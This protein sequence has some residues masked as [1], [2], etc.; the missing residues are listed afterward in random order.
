MQSKDK[1]CEE[2]PD[3]Y[4]RA[5]DNATKAQ[6]EQIKRQNELHERMYWAVRYVLQKDFGFQIDLP[7]HPRDFPGNLDD[8]E[9]AQFA[10]IYGI[11]LADN[12]QDPSLGKSKPVG[13]DIIIKAP[14]GAQQ[15][16]ILIARRFADAV[17]AAVQEYTAR[18]Q[19]FNKVFGFLK[20][21]GRDAFMHPQGA[22]G[23]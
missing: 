22:A 15:S 7:E 13:D 4:K 21:A 16:T 23:A 11:L 9:R 10:A 1:D 8:R 14:E 12:Y 5:P 2:F 18:A 19:L 17:V 3:I 20:D 6:R